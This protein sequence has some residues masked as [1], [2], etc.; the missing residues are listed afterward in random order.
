MYFFDEIVM[1]LT[2]KLE[3]FIISCVSFLGSSMAEQSA[4]N[5]WVG[6]SSP[7]RGAF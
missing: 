1:V 6:G 4:V 3:R 2:L 7:P 5:R